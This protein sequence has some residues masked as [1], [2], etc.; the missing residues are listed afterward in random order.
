MYFQHYLF[1]SDEYYSAVF[2]EN[3]HDNSIA[4]KNTED[5]DYYKDIEDIEGYL[6]QVDYSSLT[7]QFNTMIQTLDFIILVI[8][9]TAASLAFVVLVNLTQVNI[10]ERIR[11]LATLKVLGFR[12][13]EVNAY[14]F[15]EMFIL[16]FIGALI[17][18]PLGKLFHR[19][20][21]GLLKMDMVTFGMEIKIT[22]YLFSFAIT[23][24]FTVVVM[25][26]TLRSLKKI[27]MVE[28]LKSVE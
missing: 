23:I 12:N 6:S 19:F 17:G 14:I 28:S 22:S 2:D 1:I 3:I 9:I 21:M 25:I 27:Q 11:E 8:I 5:P 26:F 4:V 10:S 24:T 16:S 7:E 13:P 18:L 15:K 20:I